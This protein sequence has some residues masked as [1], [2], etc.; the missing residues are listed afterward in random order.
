MEKPKKKLKVLIWRA[1]YYGAL[2]AGGFATYYMS[3][4]NAFLKNGLDVIFVSS[5]NMILPKDV[6]FHLI[7]HNKLLKNLPEVLNLPY[8][9]KAYK[10]VKTIIKNE[11]PDFIYLQHHDFQYLSYLVKSDFDIPFFMHVDGVQSWVKKN[12]GKLYLNKIH[13]KMEKLQLQFSDHIFVP[14]LE[15]KMNLIEYGVN[16]NKISVD[17]S[18]VDPELFSPEL[19]DLDLKN[20]LGLMNHFICGFAGTF[21]HWHGVDTIAES[22]KYVKDKIPNVKFLLVG[23]GLFRAK[24]EEILKRDQTQEYCF[25][26]GMVPLSKVPNYLSICDILLTPCKSNEDNSAFFNSPIKLYEYMAMGKPIVA[27]KIGQQAIVLKHNFTAL[28]HKE[29]DSEAHANAIVELYNNKDLVKK[30][31][32]NARQ[33]VEEKYDWK[34]NAKRIVNQFYKLTD[35]NDLIEKVEEFPQ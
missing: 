18:S 10:K 20:E 22:I 6:D 30:I 4:S 9:H 19:Y 3:M 23:D 31:G 17:P 25:I 34:I 2:T 15:I 24:V 35:Q 13:Y 33:E 16:S 8:N 12:W 21:G 29:N 28:L 32:E 1:E 14:S 5:G 11:K 26:T 27:S 7:K